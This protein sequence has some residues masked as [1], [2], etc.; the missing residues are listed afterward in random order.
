MDVHHWMRIL[1]EEHHWMR[2]LPRYRTSIL[3]DEHLTAREG[4]ES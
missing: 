1:L 3:L 4:W 2:I